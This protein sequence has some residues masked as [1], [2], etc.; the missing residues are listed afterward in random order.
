MLRQSPAWLNFVKFLSV[1]CLML[2]GIFRIFFQFVV[3]YFLFDIESI[4]KKGF[5]KNGA[6]EF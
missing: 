6:W 1:L 4:W 3:S 5:L 2:V